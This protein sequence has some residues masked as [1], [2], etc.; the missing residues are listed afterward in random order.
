MKTTVPG[1][2]LELQADTDTPLGLLVKV[3]DSLKA[4]GFAIN[5]V[6]ARIGAAA[7][8]PAP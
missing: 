8:K 4:A 5:E 2:K 7:A 6:P 1:L 3:W